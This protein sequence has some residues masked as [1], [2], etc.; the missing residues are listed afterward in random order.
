MKRNSLI[1]VLICIFFLAAATS[2]L[3]ATLQVGDKS[4]SPGSD[5]Q[6]PIYAISSVDD[7]TGVAGAAFTLQFDDTVLTNPNITSPF[8]DT[9]E[10][11]LTAINPDHTGPFTADGYDK[12]LV[13]NAL[14]GTG[15]AVAAASA[16]AKAIE[17]GEGTIIF[18]LNATVSADWEP[19]DDS[20]CLSV[21]VIPTE[22]NNA[23]AGYDAGG[24]EI[25]LLIGAD[26]NITD[27]A[28]P[29]A[30]PVLLSAT[31]HD[32][33]GSAGEF[34]PPPPYTP[35]NVTPSDDIVNATDALFIL[36]YVAGN[37]GEDM[38]I[39]NA[40]DA[41]QDG[42]ITATDA[43]IIL[44]YVVGDIDALPFIP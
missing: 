25:D 24:E 4:A 14:S 42:A 20:D 34:C 40:A 31:A 16:Q 37:I 1:G 6:I 28:D 9:F 13:D 23:N 38:L 22:L 43:L 19:I 7:A 30:F 44:S 3:S 5:V 2:A 32:P 33:A 26:A 17:D 29:N 41:F 39:I 18:Y 36:A 10:A 8:F 21:T 15:I 27:P 11:Q 12:P 35:G